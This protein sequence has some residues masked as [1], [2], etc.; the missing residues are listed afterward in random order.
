MAATTSGTKTVTHSIAPHLPASMLTTLLAT[1]LE[2]LTIG[3]L[4]QLHDALKADRGRR[5][6]GRHNRIVADLAYCSADVVPPAAGAAFF[7][8]YL[9]YQ[10]R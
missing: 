5:E 9:P 4:N 6:P 3:Q 1:P 10:S 2:A 8:T 7:S